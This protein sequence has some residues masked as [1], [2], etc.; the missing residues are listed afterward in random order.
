M[1]NIGISGRRTTVRLEDEM[2]E[3]LKDVAELGCSLKAL[4]RRIYHHKKSNANFSSPIRV[5]LLL[6]YRVA[7]TEAGHA[8][9][10]HA[11]LPTTARRSGKSPRGRRPSATHDLEAMQG[12]DGAPRSIDTGNPQGWC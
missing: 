9:A 7:A 4:A 6:Y 1:H 5:F 8:K 3:S 2:W 11:S 10:G 12:I